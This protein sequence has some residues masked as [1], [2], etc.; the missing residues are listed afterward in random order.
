MTNVAGVST[1]LGGVAGT[2][3]LIVCLPRVLGV[4]GRCSPFF[5]ASPFCDKSGSSTAVT[6]LAGGRESKLFL[7]LEGLL[8][9]LN[10]P[11]KP[12]EATAPASTE[13][14]S[15]PRFFREPANA[16]RDFAMKFW[17]LPLPDGD[18][19]SSAEG[20]MICGMLVVESD[21]AKVRLR[22]DGFGPVTTLLD[23]ALIS[24]EDRVR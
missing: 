19:S 4:S 23:C 11:R 3:V 24:G 21:G 10:N 14:L 22:I 9:T 20:S 2:A 1:R 15:L 12:P 18:S 8:G 17:L 13:S 7:R 5:D 6:A 16:P